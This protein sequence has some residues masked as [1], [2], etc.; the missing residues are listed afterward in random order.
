MSRTEAQKK[1]DRKYYGARYK[2]VSFKLNKVT[3]AA[4]VEHL[5]K[6][7]NVRA[8][9]ISLI[10]MDMAIKTLFNDPVIVERSDWMHEDDELIGWDD[11]GPS[12]FDDTK[13]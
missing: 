12:K 7:D 13:Y 1:A 6:I 4:V 9:L 8:Y 2:Q 10:Q 11:M 5:E 3:D